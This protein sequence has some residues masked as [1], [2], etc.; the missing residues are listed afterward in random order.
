[1]VVRPRPATE[2]HR[3]KM[4][5]LEP[6]REQSYRVLVEAYGRNAMFDEATRI[7]NALCA[8]LEREHSVPPSP[9]TAAVARRVFAS[10]ARIGPFLAPEQAES[11]RPRVAFLA[12]SWPSGEEQPGCSSFLEDI[13]NELGRHRSFVVLAPHSSLKIDHEL[14]HA[15]STIP[16][17]GSTIRSAVSSSPTMAGRCWRCAWSVVRASEM[18][19]VRRILGQSEAALLKSFSLLSLRV[20]SSLVLGDRARAAGEVLRKNATTAPICTIWRASNGLP[21]ATSAAS[22][23]PE[24]IQA[25]D[26][27]RSPLCAA[28]RPHRPDAVSGMDPARGPRPDLLNVGAGAIGYRAGAGSERCDRSLDEGHGGALSARLRRV[29]VQT[30]GGRGAVP[31]LGRSAGAVRRRVVS[32]RRSGCRLAQIRAC[33]RS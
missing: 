5:A 8:M 29:R 25:V 15:G 3:R 31:E 14:G 27:Y 2:H 7:Y 6:E 1:M 10:R 17:C 11:D 32:S 33:D 13:A 16:S 20:A 18:M 24:I 22:P 28:A 19:L 23:G 12:P 9:E 26:R 4:L 30:G 21:T